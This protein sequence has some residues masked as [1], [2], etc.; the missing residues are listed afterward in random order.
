MHT[1]NQ[2]I[3]KFL[4]LA[5]TF[6]V[7]TIYSHVDSSMDMPVQKLQQCPHSTLSTIGIFLEHY[8]DFAI[9]QRVCVCVCVRACVRV[10][11]CTK[12]TLSH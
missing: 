7:M 12:A 2:L 3:I 10:H 9:A 4:I 11:T 8:H 6:S 1:Y 5:S